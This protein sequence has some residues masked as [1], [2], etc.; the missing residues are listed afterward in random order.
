MDNS[1]VNCGKKLKLSQE[2]NK[3]AHKS[4]NNTD[5]LYYDKFL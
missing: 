1:T 5:L 2:C 4:E 3:S